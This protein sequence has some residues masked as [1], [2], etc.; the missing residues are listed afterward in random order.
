MKPSFEELH[1]RTSGKLSDKWDL[2]LDIYDQALASYRDA[3]ISLLE[4]G[5]QN[6]G[7]LETWSNFFPSA[8]LIIGCDINPSCASLK[9]E[10]PRIIVVV[11][12]ATEPQIVQ[13]LTSKSSSFDVIIEDGSHLSSDIVRSFTS[14]FP[15][16]RPG[17]IYLAEDLHCCYWREF[18]GGLQSPLS[19]IEFFKDLVDCLHV[20][21]W[22]FPEVAPSLLLTNFRN[23][24]KVSI[25]D[26]VLQSIASI[27]FFDS[28]CIIRRSRHT[29]ARISKRVIGGTVE[30]VSGGHHTL[31]SYA[32]EPSA[33]ELSSANRRLLLRLTA[34][35]K[36]IWMRSASKRVLKFFV[37][38]LRKL[39]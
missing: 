24:Y 1:Q 25:D 9:F 6:G 7:S 4:I 12:D 31:S 23:K 3:P 10:D 11:G 15:L 2:Y 22:G 33:Q 35:D 28:V 21:Y 8:E 37:R 14:Y 34:Y 32:L 5:V 30:E 26:D 38:L 13:K 29:P 18:G 19:G 20:A 39:R 16:L 27:E 17:G 36:T